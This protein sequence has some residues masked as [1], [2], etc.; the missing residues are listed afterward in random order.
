MI[1][2]RI[3]Q[4][5][6]FKGIYKSTFYK[7]VGL[8]NGFLDKATKDIGS[9]KVEQ[10]LIAYPE[11]NPSWL[12]TGKGDMLKSD[13]PSTSIKESGKLYNQENEK[14]I[15]EELEKRR[16]EDKELYEK[17]ILSYKERIS[18]LKEEIVFLREQLKK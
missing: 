3:L 5:I 4:F 18:E 7:E 1:V 17:L 6:H 15:I 11:I 12:L 16:R 9:S 10:M 2:D 13:T 8:S 14:N